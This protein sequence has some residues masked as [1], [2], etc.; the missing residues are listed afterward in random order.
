MQHCEGKLDRHSVSTGENCRALVH[1]TLLIWTWLKMAEWKVQIVRALAEALFPALDD[2]AELARQADKEAIARFLETSA[3][4]MDFVIAAVSVLCYFHLHRLPL[5][6]KK[7][8][9]KIL[10]AHNFLYAA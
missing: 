5:S 2:D 8:Y 4:S 9:S 1:V 10:C 6:W 3:A 7:P